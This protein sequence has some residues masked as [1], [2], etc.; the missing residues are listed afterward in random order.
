MVSIPISLNSEKPA[1][2]GIGWRSTV[3]YPKKGVDSP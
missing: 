1:T 2:G 3:E